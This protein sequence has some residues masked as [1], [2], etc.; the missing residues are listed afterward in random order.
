MNNDYLTYYY[1]RLWKK[2]GIIELLIHDSF[3]STDDTVPIEETI[4]VCSS[5]ISIGDIPEIIG[6][7]KKEDVDDFLFRNRDDA[8]NYMQREMKWTIDYHEKQIAAL[9]REE[10]K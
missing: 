6:E 9:Q 2:F 4:V 3:F 5:K 7:L 10:I 1:P 8:V